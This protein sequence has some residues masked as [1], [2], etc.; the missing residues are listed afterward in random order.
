[1]RIQLNKPYKIVDLRQKRY[2]THYNIPSSESLVVPTKYL[3]DEVLCD[4][5]WESVSGERNVLHKKM[6]STENL[7]PLNPL[8]DEK[9][10]Y[11]WADFYKD[12]SN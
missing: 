2:E 6:F 3:G 7:V 8:A 4:V 9:L 11:L 5:R 10:Y 1:M 12:L